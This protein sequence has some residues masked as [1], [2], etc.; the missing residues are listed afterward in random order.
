[1][2][3]NRRDV[4]E[5]RKGREAS[6]ETILVEKSGRGDWTRTSDLVV[7]DHARYQLR[8]TPTKLGFLLPRISLTEAKQ[9]WDEVALGVPNDA[10]YQL[11]HTP[12]RSI[13]AVWS[14]SG[15]G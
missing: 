2:T 7:P 13:V 12:A 5:T 6:L 10:R 9:L 1:M 4:T 8:H 15:K 14:L 3:G 11:R